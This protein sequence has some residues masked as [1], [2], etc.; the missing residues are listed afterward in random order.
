MTEASKVQMLNI[1]EIEQLNIDEF[2]GNISKGSKSLNAFFVYRKVF[3]KR[4]IASGIKMRMTDI[5]K[6]AAQAWSSES[7]EIKKAYA[8]VSKRIDNVL[9]KKRQ[10][11]M[12]YQIVYDGNMNNFQSPIPQER[13]SPIESPIESPLESPIL[14][15]SYPDLIP[16]TQFSFPL[17][18][19]PFLNEGSFPNEGSFFIEGSFPNDPLF[20][21]NSCYNFLPMDPIYDPS[22]DINSYYNFL[23]VDQIIDLYLNYPWLFQPQ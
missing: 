20:D 11:D 15:P 23:S 16:G 9:Q 7:P 8:D 10:K 6:F 17:N 2:A 1:Q 4:A 18:D 21:I 13:E 5:S 19:G 12:T 22:F 14:T 3:T